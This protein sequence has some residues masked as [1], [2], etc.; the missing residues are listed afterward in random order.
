MIDLV[1]AQRIEKRILL[2][3]GDKVLLDGDLAELYESVAGCH[4]RLHGKAH[5]DNELWV[6]SPRN[7]R[8]HYGN[9]ECKG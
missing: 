3:R 4:E 6:F 8:Y 1:P 7:Q 5:R 9:G 2:L